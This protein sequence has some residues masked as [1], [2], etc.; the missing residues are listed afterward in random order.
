M[1][2]LI[3]ILFNLATLYG[4]ALDEETTSNKD[5]LPVNRLL[6]KGFSVGEV[7]NRILVRNVDQWRRIDSKYVLVEGR[8]KKNSSLIEF[9]NDCARSKHATF[10]YEVRGSTLTN[11]DIVKIVDYPIG[12]RKV[13]IIDKIYDL[14]IISTE[15]II[16]GV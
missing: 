15:G 10:V 6:E 5:E 1:K 16:S 3:V 13:C 8:S 4:F 14:D 7:S 9:K 12:I 2:I 11:L